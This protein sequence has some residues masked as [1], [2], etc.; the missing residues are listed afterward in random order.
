M[1]KDYRVEL[2]VKNNRLWE[3]MQSAGF[4]TVADLAKA[5][6]SSRSPIDHLLNLK[7]TAM[8]ENG[9]YRQIVLR[10]AAVLKCIPED[11]FPK[12]QLHN[13][14]ARSTAAFTMDASEVLAVTSSLQSAAVSPERRLLQQD[15]QRVIAQMLLELTPREQRVLEL[16]FG[17]NGGKEHTLDDI[18]NMFQMSREAIRAI[19]NKA[20]RRLKH[21][22]RSRHLRECCEDILID[23]TEPL[24]K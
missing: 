21:P 9:E 15:A 23:P 14:V 24:P 8:T 1:T 2:K 18:A 7:Q 11:L 3:K 5:I 12:E 22:A 13:K 10:I 4:P 20:L 19:E 17:L 6:G 16:R